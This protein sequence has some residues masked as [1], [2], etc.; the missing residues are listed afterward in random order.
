MLPIRSIN[1]VSDCTSVCRIMSHC[2]QAIM[3][4]VNC[5]THTHWVSALRSSGSGG[6]CMPVDGCALGGR[7]KYFMA[8]CFWSGGARVK[9]VDDHSKLLLQPWTVVMHASAHKCAQTDTKTTKFNE[10]NAAAD[11]KKES[12]ENNVGGAY[13]R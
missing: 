11:Y 2:W 13:K 10:I 8:L 12:K 4:I 3:S 6:G 9:G 7:Q 5:V 1:S